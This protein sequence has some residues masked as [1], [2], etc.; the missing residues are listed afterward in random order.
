MK[1]NSPTAKV[2]QDCPFCIPGLFSQAVASKGSVFAI[3]DKHP[4]TAGH[5]LIIPRRHSEDF[6]AMTEQERREAEELMFILRDKILASDPSVLGFN[7][8]YLLHNR[9]SS[10]F[11]NP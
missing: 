10:P 11:I 6:F 8:L 4:V 1:T 9:H 5:L 3:R 7:S 2:S